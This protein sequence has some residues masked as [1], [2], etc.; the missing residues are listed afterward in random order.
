MASRSIRPLYIHSEVNDQTARQRF[1]LIR[2]R[3]HPM[4]LV[5][6]PVPSGER[7]TVISFLDDSELDYT[8]IEE[9]SNREYEAMLLVPVS[10]DATDQL[11]DGL[12][13]IGIQE[14][15]FVA[16]SDLETLVSHRYETSDETTGV[17]KESTDNA[18]IAHEE[19]LSQAE[20]MA[21]SGPSYF[22][23][24]ALS[25]VVATAGLL[26]DS[27][28]VIVGSMV[29][30]PLLGPAIG[31]SVG[32]M[33]HEPELFREGVRAQVLGVVLA[34][35]SALVFS[36]VVRYTIGAGIEIQTH[37]QI[38][39][40]TNP[41]VLSVVIAIAS[42]VAGA[43]A[44]TTGASA[45]L[46]GVMIAAALIPPAAAVGIGVAFGDP[47]LAAST[48]ILVLV[49]VLC[50]NLAG[51]AV[52]WMRGYRPKRYRE[53]KIARGQAIKQFVVLLVCVLLLSSFLVGTTLD[54]TQD[55]AFEND[56]ERV[57]ANT[58]ATV[59]SHSVSYETN[60]FRGRRPV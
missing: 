28:A 58:D 2:R 15:G 37:Q 31:A 14:R 56:V 50:I 39:Q 47:V 34:V 30:A 9:V 38:A 44:F 24:I 35:V 32:R 20:Q 33:I 17:A 29:I 13:D 49:N 11:M 59:L 1:Y 57:M 54:A 19:L 27:A 45:V 41:G 51:M 18:R 55:A 12:R 40:R 22:T 6:F 8:L 46:V 52:L 5:Q 7:A 60:L 26:T 4:R 3:F 25:A 43:L 53:E 16:V 42:G 21:E 10:T 36:L 48:A 23:L